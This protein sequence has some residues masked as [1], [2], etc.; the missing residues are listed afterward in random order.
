MNVVISHTNERICGAQDRKNQDPGWEQPM[1][2]PG[3]ILTPPPITMAGL[4]GQSLPSSR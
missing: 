4:P 2:P 1:N 3:A